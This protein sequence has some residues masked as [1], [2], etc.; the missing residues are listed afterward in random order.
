MNADFYD[1]ASKY[2]VI[3]VIECDSV[4]GF[5]CLIAVCFRQGNYYSPFLLLRDVSAQNIISS[6]HFPSSRLYGLVYLRWLKGRLEYS[7]IRSLQIEA[8]YF[9]Q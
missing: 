5:W 4:V 3:R 1:N 2:L 6:C 9:H 7:L 8:D